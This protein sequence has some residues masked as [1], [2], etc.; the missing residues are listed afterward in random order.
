MVVV[1]VVIEEVWRGRTVN[2]IVDAYVVPSFSE[3][4]FAIVDDMASILVDIFF[5]VGSGTVGSIL[6]MDVLNPRN[7]VTFDVTFSVVSFT[8]VLFSLPLKYM[9]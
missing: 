2:L 7:V 6:F 9:H 3:T 8:V 5:S 1:D 4:V